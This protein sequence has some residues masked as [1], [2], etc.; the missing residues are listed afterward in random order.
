MEKDKEILKEYMLKEI[1]IIEDIIKRM[2]FNSFLIKGWAVTL[3][4]VAL[5]LK[6]G[7]IQN[8]IAFFPLFAF[9]YLDAFFLRQERAYRKLYEWVIQNRLKTDEKLFDMNAGLRFDAEVDPIRQIMV[10]KTLKVFYGTILFILMLY[11]IL[12]FIVPL[13]MTIIMSIKI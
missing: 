1:D 3:I 13:L 6:G 7:T 8:S 11:N 5:L 4:S 10:S 2:A 12:L 9:W